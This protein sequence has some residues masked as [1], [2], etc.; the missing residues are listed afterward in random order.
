[1]KT[2]GV[3]VQRGQ[4]EPFW[5]SFVTE[6]ALGLDMEGEGIKKTLE[7]DGTPGRIRTCDLLLRR[8]TLYPSELQAHEP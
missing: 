3:L 1:M 7:L 6:A 2:K 5:Y 8:Q 4:I